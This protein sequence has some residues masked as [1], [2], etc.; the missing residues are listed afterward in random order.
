MAGQGYKTIVLSKYTSNGDYVW[1]KSINGNADN[2]A[3]S[4]RL[5]EAGNIFIGGRFDGSTDFDPSGATATLTSLGTYNGFFLLNI[6]I[7]EIICGRISC[8]VWLVV[9]LILMI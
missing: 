9:K 1:S 7:K 5:D 8:R 6:P 2:Y 3:H 4:M